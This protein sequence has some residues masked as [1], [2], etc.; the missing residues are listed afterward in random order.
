MK[1]IVVLFTL[2]G[3]PVPIPP[4]HIVFF[5]TKVQCEKARVIVETILKEKWPQVYG[6]QYPLRGE[7]VLKDVV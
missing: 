1:W 2:T 6:Q 4:S 7:C 5:D 3:Q